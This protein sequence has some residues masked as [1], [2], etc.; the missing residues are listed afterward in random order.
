MGANAQTSVPLYV[1][2]E[3]LTAAD[4]NISAGTG[5]PVFATTVTRDAAFGGAGEKVLAEG[6]LAYLEDSNIVQYYTGAAWATVGP[7][8]SSGLISMVPTSVAVGSGT[9]TASANGQVTFAGASS[10][11]LNGV[12]TSSYQNY[13]LV[14]NAS[15]V[16]GS[17]VLCR[18][19]I[20]GTDTTA[21]NYNHQLLVA[22]NTTVSGARVTSD[23]SIL[24]MNNINTVHDSASAEIY[25]PQ[26]TKFTT[27]NVPSTSTVSTIY[28][29]TI[30]GSYALTTSFDGITLFSASNL[31]G[32]VTVY[33]YNQ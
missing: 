31:T 33:G 19:R 26:A 24:F 6:Q 5:V 3:V 21:A 4:M 28:Y 15:A 8:S 14:F 7:S 12:F 13:R 10:V 18:F 22:S 29:Q 11:S 1:A 20:A 30:A 23:T 25:S 27:I 9:G 17:S 2:A 32:T 16:A